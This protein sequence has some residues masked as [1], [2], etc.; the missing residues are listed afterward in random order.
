MFIVKTLKFFGEL[1][2]CRQVKNLRRMI[3][4]FVWFRRFTCFGIRIPVLFETAQIGKDAEDH[5]H[6]FCFEKTANAGYSIGYSGFVHGIQI[7]LSIVFYGSEKN[8]HVGI[9]ESSFMAIVFFP[10]HP[11]KMLNSFNDESYFFGLCGKVNFIK[12][13]FF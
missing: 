2:L 13:A 9:G 3:I 11:K 10:L 4:N 8:S 6:F 5:I 1:V 12:V 7:G